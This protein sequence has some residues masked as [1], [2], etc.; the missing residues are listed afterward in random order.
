MEKQL[1]SQDKLITNFKTNVIQ[2]Q[3]KKKSNAG[4]Y[5]TINTEDPK[6]REKI[7]ADYE[8]NTGN[9]VTLSGPSKQKGS[10]KNGLSK[11]VKNA[12]V[13]QSQQPG[14]MNMSNSI[15]SN[16]FHFNEGM[17]SNENSAKEL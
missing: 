1:P 8:R 6:V 3:K 4:D 10:F 13:A 7:Q 14:Q 15:P 12:A 9:F 17:M 11:Q 16:H 5:T 2:F